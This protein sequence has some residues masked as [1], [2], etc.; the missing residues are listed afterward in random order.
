MEVFVLKVLSFGDLKKQNIMLTLSWICVQKLTCIRVQFHTCDIVVI[1]GYYHHSIHCTVLKFG[2]SNSMCG[3]K[4]MWN[5]LPY[6]SIK[7]HGLHTVGT[8]MVTLSHSTRENYH[9]VLKASFQMGRG[10]ITETQPQ[11]SS[12][13]ENHPTMIPM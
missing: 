1:F 2:S 3:M 13:K 10:D 5:S 4:T 7:C 6:N 8:L 12:S 11:N 9:K